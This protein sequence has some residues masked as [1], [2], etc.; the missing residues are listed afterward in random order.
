MRAR[1]AAPLQADARAWVI[2]TC[3]RQGFNPR[4]RDRAVLADVAR[5]IAGVAPP[6]TCSRPKPRRSAKAAP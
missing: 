6:V 4:V 2:R 3:I 1:A 5:L